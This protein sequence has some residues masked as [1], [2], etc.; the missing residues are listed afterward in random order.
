MDEKKR[1]SKTKRRAG[2]LFRLL[3][4]LMILGLGWYAYELGIPGLVLEWAEERGDSG[5]TAEE[6]ERV[7]LDVPY[8]NQDELGYPVGCEMTAAL[9]A[10]EQEGIDL[11]AEE[12]LSYLP[13]EEVYEKGGKMWGPDPGKS[14]AGN[15]ASSSGYGCFAPVIREAL[16]SVI[17]DTG[18]PSL[19]VSDLTGSTLEELKEEIDRGIPVILWA[20]SGMK[21]IT[22]RD[23]WYI[24]GKTTP[25]F[26]PRG[27]PCLLLIGYQGDYLFF[28]DPQGEAEVAYHRD[29]V[30][31]PYRELG[32]QALAIYNKEN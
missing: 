9:M 19:A 7:L 24:E 6:R 4:F 26:W 12:F 29:E 22:Y 3:L 8:L 23:S 2:R 16:K 25:Y 21:E 15:P 28:H 27:E 32:Q 31:G 11:T 20:S 18:D 14:F 5:R 13:M 1:A 30:Q 17:L 10:L